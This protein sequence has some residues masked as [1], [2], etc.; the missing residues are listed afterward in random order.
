MASP[1]GSHD[2]TAVMVQGRKVPATLPEKRRGS[3]AGN[4]KGAP[5]R[6]PFD[7]STANR[8]SSG[9]VIQSGAGASIR[10]WSKY[11]FILTAQ[12]SLFG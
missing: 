12:S 10:K 2:V 3:D 8:P 4:R 9:C 5:W 11:S 6:P 7:H 1:N